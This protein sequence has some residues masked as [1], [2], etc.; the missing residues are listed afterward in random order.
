MMWIEIDLSNHP[1]YFDP[2]SMRLSDYIDEIGFDPRWCRTRFS[3]F[4]KR[5][6]D[7]MTFQYHLSVILELIE[8]RTIIFEHTKI[9]GQI[10]RNYEDI[11]DDIEAWIKDN[12]VDLNSDEGKM[13]FKLVWV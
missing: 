10:F 11:T 13:R 6:Y 2:T 4:S 1:D 12:N 9:R 5:L 8:C 3:S 7:G